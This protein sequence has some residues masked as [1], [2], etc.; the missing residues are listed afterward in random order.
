MRMPITS[1]MAM[2]EIVSSVSPSAFIAKSVTPSEVGIATI[3][4]TALRHDPRKNSITNAVRMMPSISVC[5]TLSTCSRV[6]VD[7]TCAT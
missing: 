6:N 2:S 1:V 7:C 5:S 3:T 4:T